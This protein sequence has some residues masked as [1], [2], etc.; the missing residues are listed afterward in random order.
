MAN[1]GKSMSVEEAASIMGK[2]MQF[3]RIGLQR[4]RLPF[5]SAVKMS[6]KWTYYISRSKFFEYI[7][8][9]QSD[10]KLLSKED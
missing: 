1:E 3:V 9:D 2:S 8:C 5:G 7:G 10:C 4:E 6:K